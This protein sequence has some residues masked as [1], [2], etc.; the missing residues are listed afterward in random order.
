MLFIDKLFDYFGA[1]DKRSDLN[2]DV[3]GRGIWERY[4]RAIGKSIDN[5]CVTLID[6][7][8]KNIYDPDTCFSRYVQYLESMLGYN[9]DLNTLYLSPA[10][11]ARRRMLK[12]ILRLYQIKGT[13]RAY[14]L[15]FGMLGFG[16]TLVENFND[17][18]FDSPVTFDDPV[19]RFDMK[20]DTCST[21]VINLT[22]GGPMTPELLQAVLSIIEF[23][24]PINARL[25]GLN[26]NGINIVLPLINDFD[27]SYDFSFSS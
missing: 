26:Y 15:L 6:N 12:K 18:S 2:K 7:L 14:T 19:R 24:Q 10:I 17:Y 21:Y 4:N 3:N 13:K 27:F 1:Y 5:E 20:C 22:G 25:T 9:K 16:V 8:M 11:P 23:N